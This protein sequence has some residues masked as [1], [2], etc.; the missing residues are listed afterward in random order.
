MG[1]SDEVS[2]DTIHEAG[3]EPLWLVFMSVLGFEVLKG[4]GS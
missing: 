4:E 1:F 2:T 3:T